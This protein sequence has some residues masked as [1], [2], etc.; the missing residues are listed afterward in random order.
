MHTAEAKFIRHS[1]RT[2]EMGIF[3]LKAAGEHGICERV[4]H[5][6]CVVH[7]YDFVFAGVESDLEWARQQME[8]SF[9]VKVIGRLGGDKQD[10]RELRVLNRVLSWGSGAVQLEA[11][12]RHQEILIIELEQA[13]RGKM[14]MRTTPT[15]CWMK[16][17]PTASDR[18]QPVRS[19]SRWT[20]QT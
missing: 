15:V 11:D 18:Q 1:R 16:L 20:D 10:V 9:L 2:R 17:K 19:T 8:K 5:L 3:S 14:D 12:P 13:R 6:S 4:G 7:G